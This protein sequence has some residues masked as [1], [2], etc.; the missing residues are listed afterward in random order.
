MVTRF[1]A[2]QSAGAA[3]ASATLTIAASDS[4]ILSRNHADYLCGGVS[5]Q[6]VIREAIAALPS[7]GGR[8][9]LL[10]GTFT[11]TGA[12]GVPDNCTIEG[13]GDSTLIQW[14]ENVGVGNNTGAIENSD[15]AGGNENIRIA[16]LRIK[17]NYAV[18]DPMSQQGIQM[19]LVSKVVIEGVHFTDL[20]GYPIF[21]IGGGARNSTDN[22]IIHNKFTLNGSSGI[23][24]SSASLD[25]LYRFIIS[26]NLLV[27][28]AGHGI[29]TSRLYD[30]IISNNII[31]SP[32]MHGILFDVSFRCI[33]YGNTII[34]S[35][36]S[37]IWFDMSFRNIIS[38]NLIHDC[39]WDGIAIGMTANGYF[40][41]LGNICYNNGED[42][43]GHWGVTLRSV[44]SNNVCYENSQKT[45][46]TYENLYI[47][48]VTGYNIVNGN[49]VHQSGDNVCKYGIRIGSGTD[50]IATNNQCDN[51][52]GDIAGEDFSDAG[53]TTITGNNNTR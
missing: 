27:N 24:I 10:E 48:G 44:L 12:I 20:R 36:K 7:S 5:D 42:G 19:T 17:G 18:G 6:G 35:S 16:N 33:V 26:E 39:D 40:N 49:S 4:P 38:E 34:E 53:T 25:T 11:I 9:V 8:I 50:S 14:A 13:Q 43:I 1:W 45:P 22:R 52:G 23:Y 28:G 31:Y 51:G 15:P 37:G 46:N 41:I 29:Q 3:Q 21:F 2:G 32:S 47:G 30:S